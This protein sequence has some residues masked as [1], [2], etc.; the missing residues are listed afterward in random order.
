MNLDKARFTVASS[1]KDAQRKGKTVIVVSEWGSIKEAL[2]DYTLTED[3]FTYTDSKS[4]VN[5]WEFNRKEMGEVQYD[6]LGRPV[7]FYNKSC[8]YF[9]FY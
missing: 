7:V 4:N 5:K 6:I 3:K 1:I 2:Q 9:I 8:Y